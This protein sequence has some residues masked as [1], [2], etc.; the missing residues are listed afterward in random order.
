VEN[1]SS[2]EQIP[3]VSEAGSEDL[4][5]KATSEISDLKTSL[6][7]AKSELAHERAER[8]REK[9]GWESQLARWQDE[10]RKREAEKFNL[11]ERLMFWKRVGLGSGICGSGDDGE[12]GTSQGR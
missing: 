3:K 8:E 10:V 11:E 5:D 12:G 1:E 7:N 9:V 2:E 6:L 4:H